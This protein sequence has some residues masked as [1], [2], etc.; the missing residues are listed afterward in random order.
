MVKKINGLKVIEFHI[1][2]HVEGDKG[3][4]DGPASGTYCTKADAQLAMAHAIVRG[5]EVTCIAR[6][7]LGAGRRVGWGLV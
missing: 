2:E 5:N 7:R 4:E 3:L 6:N 1:E